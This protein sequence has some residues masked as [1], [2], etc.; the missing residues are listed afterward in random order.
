MTSLAYLHDCHSRYDE[1]S[2]VQKKNSLLSHFSFLHVA[3]FSHVPL[4]RILHALGM[5]FAML[6]HWVPLT[7]SL[8]FLPLFYSGLAGPRHLLEKNI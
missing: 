8:V 6:T 3:T 7:V 1:R 4:G 5:T 2:N